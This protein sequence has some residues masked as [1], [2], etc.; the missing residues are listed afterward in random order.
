M[1]TTA[2]SG[3]GHPPTGPALRSLT[4]RVHYLAGLAIGPFLVVL[5]LTGLAYAFTPTIN[6]F[7]YRDLW[8]V[9]VGGSA[10][11]PVSSGWSTRS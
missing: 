2:Q 7:V 8:T 3:N 4:R 11:R 6:E 5:C 9:D 10:P 1:S